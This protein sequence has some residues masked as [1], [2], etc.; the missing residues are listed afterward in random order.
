MTIIIINWKAWKQK[1]AIYFLCGRWGGH[2]KSF[3]IPTVGFAFRLPVILATL[4]CKAKLHFQGDKCDHLHECFK[5]A[6]A[7]FEKER[8]KMGKLLKSPFANQLGLNFLLIT[9]WTILWN[10]E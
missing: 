4:Y 7:D 6:Y 5:E 2:T 8:K 10:L 1:F 9:C 3:K